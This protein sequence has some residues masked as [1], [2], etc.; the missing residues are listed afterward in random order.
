MDQADKGKKIAQPAKVRL[1]DI[2]ERAGVSLSSVSRAVRGANI[3]ET[4]RAKIEIAM[5]ELHVDRS[6]FSKKPVEQEQNAFIALFLQD[7][8]NPF[9]AL[10]LKGIEEV[11]YPHQYGIILCDMAQNDEMKMKTIRMLS[12]NHNVAGVLYVSSKPSPAFVDIMVKEKLPLV[13]IDGKDPSDRVS[14]VCCD[15]RGGVYNAVKYL[16]SLGH[17]KILYLAGD[18][19]TSIEKERYT[20]YCD[21][22]ISAGIPVDQNLRVD[23]LGDFQR[24]YRNLEEKLTENVNFTAVFSADDL[25]AF[26][27]KRALEEHRLKV[28]EDVSL[29]GFDNQ[30]FS[31]AIS[32]TTYVRPA[33]EMGRD[34]MFLLNDLIN[35]RLL[36]PKQIVLNPTIKIRGSCRVNEKRFDDTARKISEGKTIRIGFTPPTYSEFY[37][38]ILHG[39]KTMMKELNNRFGVKFELDM[40]YPK[41]PHSAVGQIAAIEQWTER[42]FD[43]VLVCTS[44]DLEAMNEVFRKAMYAGTAVYLFNMPSEVLGDYL[45][46]TSVI[47]YDNHYQSGL[48]VGKYA[49]SQLMGSGELGV[50]R[51]LPGYWSTAR[52]KGFLEAIG[53]YDGL[54]II[55]EG[56]GE[57]SR[58]KGKEVALSLLREHPDVRLMYG[59]TDD[60][61]LGIVEAIDELGL[62]CWDGQEGILVVGA[63]GLRS[64]YKSI[65]SNRMT[66]TADVSPV[67]QGREF[68]MAVFMHE[69]LGYNVEKVINVPTKMVDKQNVDAAIAYTE[70]A[71]GVE[72]P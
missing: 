68:I 63:N 71:L 29:M 33:C 54:K 43:A 38:T 72:Y 20:G 39:A 8:L 36:K 15:N 52:R 60:M 23:G 22:L 55:G 56:Y 14:S 47:G 58:S 16:I 5:A 48:L 61:A 67:E 9:Y 19:Q 40:F 30:P 59:E 32:L 42:K 28:P 31:S 62:K 2:A 24:A 27:A 37:D 49:A 46:V 34:A 51:G 26:A 66:A 21:A 70:W 41:V 4:I 11:A 6:Y 1:V 69:A 53:P 17:H 45:N 12:E 7:I 18:S 65:V 50:V 3:D 25:M 13:L 57:Y 44:G 35:R 64:G 10:L